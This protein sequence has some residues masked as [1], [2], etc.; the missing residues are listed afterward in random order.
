MGLTTHS[1]PLSGRWRY[2]PQMIPA[3]TAWRRCTFTSSSVSVRASILAPRGS[4]RARG[5]FTPRTIGPAARGGSHLVGSVHA[6]EVE[7]TGDR[8]LRDDRQAQAPVLE[9]LGLG[10][11]DQAVAVEGGEDLGQVQRIG[12]DAMRR[13][14][15]SRLRNLLGEGEE[16][17]DQCPLGW[18]QLDVQAGGGQGA[19]HPLLPRLAP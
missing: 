19:R 14:A 5:L 3:V 16:L 6:E 12:R 1:R 11:D 2:Q 7:G 4:P 9:R 13:A 10:A 18:V 15:L 8:P 17:L